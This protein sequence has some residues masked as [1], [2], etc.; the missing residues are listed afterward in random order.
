ML[1]VSG[2]IEDMITIMMV[3]MLGE[4]DYSTYIGID[5][6]SDCIIVNINY[7]DIILRGWQFSNQLIDLYC[8]VNTICR[9][10]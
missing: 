2:H 10:V 4:Y 8:R 9:R 7:N 3:A 5:K 1:N 6:Y